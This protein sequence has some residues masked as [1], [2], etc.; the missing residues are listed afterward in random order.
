VQIDRI[1][2]S[3][4]ARGF[5]LEF[6]KVRDLDWAASLIHPTTQLEAAE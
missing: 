4:S 3:D 1:L 5:V 6:L 2:A